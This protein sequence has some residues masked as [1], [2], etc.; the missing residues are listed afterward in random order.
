MR[1]CYRYTVSAQ[2]DIFSK[3][4]PFFKQHALQT[5][6]KKEN[7]KLFC[8]IAHIT[9]QKQHLTLK[10]VKKIR[11]LKQKMNQHTIGLA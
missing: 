3:V 9:Q 10:G 4:I 5:V 1:K 8:R 11:L 7:F 2:R 6:S